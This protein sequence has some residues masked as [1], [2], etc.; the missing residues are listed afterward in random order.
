VRLAE[1]GMWSSP[2]G[3]I[4]AE[5]G[6]QIGSDVNRY[7]NWPVV[8]GTR[9]GQTFII[10]SWG[11]HFVQSLFNEEE[12]EYPLIDN[13]IPESVGARYRIAEKGIWNSAS[14]ALRFL[15]FDTFQNSGVKPP[16][17]PD[18]QAAD[19][20]GK[21]RLLRLGYGIFA[22]QL[23]PD[24]PIRKLVEG[25]PEEAKKARQAAASPALPGPFLPSDLKILCASLVGNVTA[26]PCAALFGSLL[27]PRA[28]VFRTH[29]IARRQRFPQMTTFVY[30]HTHRYEQPWPVTL[31]AARTVQVLNTGA[32]QR[33][34]NEAGFAE[35]TRAFAHPYEGLKKIALEDLPPCYSAVLIDYKDGA[36]EMQTVM[37]R[38]PEDG[39]GKLVSPGSNGCQ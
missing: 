14:E 18:N 3:R 19:V 11:E 7:E 34:I 31:D 20:S 4:V 29:L 16:A 39:P 12:R 28:E 6:H 37:W 26:T 8:T 15:A 27:L 1:S 17:A 9:N 21:A 23:A 24:S 13:L 36:P 2:D 10:R 5:H 33:L 30:G 32:F 38:M 25:N 22:G 35:K